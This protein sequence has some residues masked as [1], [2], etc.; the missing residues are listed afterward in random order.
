MALL[1]GRIQMDVELFNFNLPEARIALRP[2]SPRD[3]SRL[4]HVNGEKLTDHTARDLADL[5]RPGDV[6][7]LNE[8]KVLRASLSGVRPARA[9]GGGGDVKLGFNLHKQISGDTWRAFA[10]PAKRLKQGD[11]VH[12]S[13]AL[14]AQVTDKQNGGDVG[15]KFNLKGEDLGRAI[16]LVGEMPLP[17]YIA[18]QRQVDAQDNDD[19]QTVFAVDKGSVAAPTAGLHFTPELFAKLESA[20]VKIARLTLHVGAGTFLPMSCD[21]TDDHHMHSEWYSVDTETAALINTAKQSGGRVIAV[22]TTALRA[23]ESCANDKHEVVA[24]SA[25][26]DIFIT[27]G[28]RFKIIDG[29]LTNFHLP[30]STL[31]MLV[32]AFCGLDNMQ[33]AYKYAIDNEYR[34]YSYGDTSLLW[35]NEI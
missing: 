15:L 13:D 24:G 16:E 2:A 5:L 3:S 1:P 25:D 11:T 34:F 26:T 23:L 4:L 18:R 19:Y 7:V 33:A 17:P 21:N 27:P 32:S 8:T 28:Y 6:L 31:F 30:K 20:G 9:H 22:G 29:M 10:R 12:F 14:S 35:K